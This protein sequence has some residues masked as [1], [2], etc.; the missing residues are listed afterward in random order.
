MPTN[1]T[2]S[3]RNR[4]SYFIN[5]TAAFAVRSP[6]HWAAA[7]ELDFWLSRELSTHENEPW[8][9]G[10]KDVSEI[11]ASEKRSSEEFPTYTRNSVDK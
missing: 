3:A 4:L 11:A 1:F 9:G 5:K 6:R 10:L 2:G 8:E 7:E